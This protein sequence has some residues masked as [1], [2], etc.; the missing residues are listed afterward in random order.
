MEL[1][2]NFLDDL[3]A[4]LLRSIEA[5]GYEPPTADPSALGAAETFYRLSRRLISPTPRRCHRSDVL[6]QRALPAWQARAVLEITGRLDRGEDV[7]RFLSRQTKD[8]AAQTKHDLLLNDW[9][10]HHLHLGSELGS[11]APEADGYVTR[12]NA[13]LYVYVRPRDAYLLDVK[14]HQAFEDLDLVE[15]L[16]ANW[17]DVLEPYRCPEV[18]ELHSPVQSPSDRK[19]FRKVGITT[20]VQAQDGTVYV[21][22]G[23]GYMGSGASTHASIHAIRLLGRAR[24]LASCCEQREESI[25]EEVSRKVGRPVKKLRLRLRTGRWVLEHLEVWDVLTNA[26]VSFRDGTTAPSGLL[27]A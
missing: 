11:T 18:V 1:T 19:K 8:G 6:R 23:G 15:I 12:S 26:Q 27:G 7:Q 16:H 2:S 10:V 17:P 25:R 21:P 24:Q 20:A 3:R 5:L 4:N 13:L 22:P 14:D 9:G